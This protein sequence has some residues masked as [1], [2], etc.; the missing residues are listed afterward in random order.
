MIFVACIFL[1]F[2]VLLCFV[3]VSIGTLFLAIFVVFLRPLARRIAKSFTDEAVGRQR[4][5]WIDSVRLVAG[6]KYVVSLGRDPGRR[7][8]F[9]EMGDRV[10]MRHD[11]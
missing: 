5:L 10:P 1:Y 8:M 3:G 2:T 9:A 11:A 7:S 6:W 4:R